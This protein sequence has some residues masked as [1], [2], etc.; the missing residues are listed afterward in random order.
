MT[1]VA[2]EVVQETYTIDISGPGAALAAHYAASAAAS[3]EAAQE[4]LG[5]IQDLAGGAASDAILLVQAE[6]DDQVARVQATPGFDTLYPNTYATA[7]PREVSGITG[8]TAG[9]GGTNG[10]FALGVTGGSITGVTGTF[11]VSGGALTAVTITNGGLGSGTTPPTLSFTASSGLTGAAATAVV[12]PKVPTTGRYLALSADKK[13]VQLYQNDGTSTP[14]LVPDIALQTAYGA[15]VS[16]RY[17]YEFRSLDIAEKVFIAGAGGGVRQILPDPAI[18]ELQTAAAAIPTVWVYE[19]RDINYAGKALRA[20][21]EN[22]IRAIEATDVSLSLAALS[23]EVVAARG[24]KADLA[25]RL[26]VSQTLDG[27]PLAARQGRDHLRQIRYRLTALDRALTPMQCVITLCGDSWT[28][29]D[30]WVQQYALELTAKYGDGGGGWCP[31]GFAPGIGT[32]PWN[33]GN[34]PPLK[35]RNAR[36]SLYPN[37]HTGDW[38]ATYLT[39]PT[40]DLCCIT[41]STAGDKVVQTIPATPI[42]TGATLYFVGTADGVIRY[43]WDGGATWSANVNVQGTVGAGQTVALTGIPSGASTLTVE[44]VSGTVKL[45]GVLLTSAANGVVINQIAATGSAVSSWEAAPAGWDALFAS[46]GSHAFFYMDGTNSQGQSRAAASWGTGIGVFLDRVRAAVPGIDLLL[47]VPAEN[48]R[49]GNAVPMPDYA[50]EGRKVM[51]ARRGAFLHFQ[52]QFGDPLNVAADYGNG[53]SVPLLAADLIHPSA[54]GAR[55][56]LA[57]FLDMT[58]PFTGA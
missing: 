36:F 53:G 4:A 26:A 16:I 38:V 1:E 52:D 56:L 45:G 2:I 44:I 3:N 24:T 6:G 7:L 11:T 30:Y 31:F 47:A 9:S 18:A 39:A 43:S 50:P 8:L 32:P 27:L 35:N 55:V 48:A 42:H 46:L 21:A 28:H 51:A 57:G 17:T 33:G 12:S 5:D 37:T 58:T 13:T 20:G 15:E 22:K 34:Q 23:A 19:F 49:V 10:T 54:A 29:G 14:A 25:T 41:S 40:P